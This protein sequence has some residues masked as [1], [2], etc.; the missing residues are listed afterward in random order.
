MSSL[1]FP[2]IID[3]CCGPLGP[4]RL[5]LNQRQ[6]FTFQ[7]KNNYNLA[8]SSVTLF[9]HFRPGGQGPTYVPPH[10]TEG[11]LHSLELQVNDSVQTLENILANLG[12]KQMTMPTL[13]T[14]VSL[15]ENSNR[16]IEHHWD[17]GYSISLAEFEL[18][19]RY[20]LAVWFMFANQYASA[21]NHLMFAAKLFGK[22]D[23]L[24]MEYCTIPAE[25]LKGF[26]SACQIE[27]TEVGKSLT[28]RM[29]ESI[30]N[31]YSGFVEILQEDN[32][33]RQVPI[34]YR[35]MAAMDLAAAISV[36]ELV[37]G[38]D[39]I[40]KV[41]TLNVVRKCLEHRHIP[42]TY[43]DNLRS[44][45]S[46]GAQFFISAFENVLNSVDATEKKRIQELLVRTLRINDALLKCL[47]KSPLK[48]LIQGQQI[49][50]ELQP[51][52]LN[53]SES[54]FPRTCNSDDLL[55]LGELLRIF[56]GF[57]YSV[58]SH[59]MRRIGTITRRIVLDPRNSENSSTP[60]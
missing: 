58:T 3:G 60:R 45:G 51:M 26:L 35:E 56:F 40:F 21:K 17:K 9:V 50:T 46:V 41:Q 36:N 16:A 18:Q 42:L 31:Q 48:E 47:T 5:S 38:S 7:C 33:K 29:Y 13:E 49:K 19:L 32:L 54:G 12:D 25:D 10:V 37:V 15:T 6:Y 55:I 22:C 43:F 52:N 20:D 53:S 4:V 23:P 11:L 44:E 34:H 28:E 57:F 14:F 59:R 24:R 30:K 2:H 8:N 27:N 39:L 1:P